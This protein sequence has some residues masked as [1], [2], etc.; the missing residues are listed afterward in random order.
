[1]NYKLAKKLKEAGWPQFEIVGV[2]TKGPDGKIREQVT[3]PDLEEL[4]EACGEIIQLTIEENG[5]T[6]VRCLLLRE[7]IKGKTPTIAVANLWLE[8]NK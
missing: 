7:V 8:L 6:D 1:M 4:I 2:Q 3:Y 5:E